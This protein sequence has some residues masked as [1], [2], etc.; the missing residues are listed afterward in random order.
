V[1]K[2]RQEQGY[3]VVHE[4]HNRVWV[5]VVIYDMDTLVRLDMAETIGERLA[6]GE[7]TIEQAHLLLDALDAAEFGTE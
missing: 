1:T 2:R 5:E 3:T 7:I 6:A 4:L